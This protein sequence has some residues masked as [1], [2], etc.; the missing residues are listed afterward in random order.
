MSRLDRTFTA[1]LLKSPNKG[2][3]T[4]V[5]MPGS[6][7]YSVP[8]PWS[9]SAAP[10]MGPTSRVL[11][12]HLAMAR[13][14]CPSRP[15]CD[16][17]SVGSRRHG[18]HL[19]GGARRLTLVSPAPV[20]VSEVLAH[21]RG[22]VVWGHPA[23]QPDGFPDLGE[24]FGAVRAACQVL[25]EAAPGRPRERTL[26]VVG[27]HLHHLLADEVTAE[28]KLHRDLPEEPSSVSSACRSLPR[29]R[30]SSTRWFASLIASTEQTSAPLRPSTSRSSTTSRWRAG[31]P[32]TA[33]LSRSASLPAS[34]RSSA[35]S[36]QC[37]GGV[38]HAPFGPKRDASTTGPA[39]A[40]GIDRCSRTP[41][42]RARLTRMVNI[43]VRSDDLPSKLARPRSTASQVS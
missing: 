21:L 23:G 38:D 41:V 28:G 5:V 40:T 1:T 26:Q 32:R 42:D 22:E 8:A 4:Y 2:G 7:E 39:S 20:E 36:I 34:I 27:Y 19:P 14:S 15:G 24:V 16:R 12:W 33:D 30:C 37:S 17:R 11:S 6:V 25:L 3:W 10:S 9:R 29:P 13:T 31:R 43:Q 35:S 18:N